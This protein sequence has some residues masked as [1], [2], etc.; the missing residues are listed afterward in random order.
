MKKY[1]F[2]LISFCIIIILLLGNKV[3]AL[4]NEAENQKL[5]Y[6]DI[7]I[8]TDGSVTV[9]EAMWLN[10]DYNG[11]NREIEFKDYSA[12]PFTGIYSNFSGDTDIYDA[13]GISNI[14][15]YDISQANFNSLKDINNIEKE[16]K[17]VKKASKGKYGVYT[18]E[19]KATHSDVSIYCPSKK[20]KVLYLEYTIEDA[21][22]VHNDVAELYWCFAENIS[23]ETILDYQ[24]IVHLPQED[25]NVM[26]WSHGPPSGKC[27][28]VDYKTLSLTD[29][30]I[31]PYKFET[32][33]IMFDKKLVPQAKKTSNV[34]GKE[35]IIKYEKAMADPNLAAEE[36]KKINIENKLSKEFQQ[37]EKDY[38]MFL[39]ND[40]NELLEKLTW[41][42]ELKQK[43]KEKLEQ[44]K[45]K[46]N[47]KWKESIEWDFDFM[48]KYK[49]ISQYKIDSVRKEIDEGFDEEAKAMYNAKADELQEQLNA[50]KKANKQKV[51]AIV[52]ISYSILG[53]ISV[54]VLVKIFIEKK[55]YNKKYYR[56]FP[57]EDNAYI[58]DYLMN[59]KVTTK[60][61]LV[62]ILDL[63]SKKKILLEKNINIEDDIIFVLP[64]KQTARTMAENT[65][66]ETLFNLIGKDN[67]C[68][69]NQLKNYANN[70]VC[71]N[72]LIRYFQKFEKNVKKEIKEKDYFEK[73]DRCNKILK[74]LIIIIE[75]I[76][77]V[78]G[79]FING[80][81]YISVLN[82]YIITITL[83]YVYYL[84]LSND[85]G[86]TKK[87]RLE[88][89]KWLAHK[90]FLKDFGR[91]EV[92]EL[93]E[94]ILWERYFVTAVTLGCSDQ[95][96]KKL[97][98]RLVDYE[99]IDELQSMMFQYMQYKNFKNLEQTIERL[100]NNAKSNSKYSN[101]SNNSGGYSSGGG[102]GGG[103][104]SGG[105]GGGGGGWSRF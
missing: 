40:A 27:S 23:S 24:A 63:I 25:Q 11:A 45:E 6:Q 58:I 19:N 98:M 8:N 85:K 48:I 56:D 68:S 3:Y 95:V 104:S 10:G 38:Y 86:R 74:K 47:Q 77:F 62:T 72:N 97:E 84:I 70:G 76:S 79:F 28:I 100:I 31:A 17:K 35:H 51:L 1:R 36:T 93:P 87:G 13:T 57:S 21:V 2:L 102:F 50:R 53:I 49:D 83:S 59:K 91:F 14:K 37:L 64:E 82:Y 12:Y 22:V 43:Y 75:V 90:R 80:N 16:F 26:V 18:V 71:S 60:T 15:V 5:L 32:L 88:Y 94:I 46:V 52:A 66:I 69:L 78:L 7:T 4:S 105:S 9:K 65:V 81:G 20:E 96:L 67:R 30:N 34:N 54:L 92:K 29:T 55:S 89:S 41:N 103:S 33:R 61:F 39:Y 44:V 101:S 99:A 42:D 73:N